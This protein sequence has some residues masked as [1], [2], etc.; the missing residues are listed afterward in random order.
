MVTGHE[1]L[2]AHAGRKW[3]AELGRNFLVWFIIVNS[4]V[5]ELNLVFERNHWFFW[6]EFKDDH[7]Y[8][9]LE[10][11]GYPEI[12]YT[13]IHSHS[14]HEQDSLLIALTTQRTR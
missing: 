5:G 8:I 6:Y 10:K 14:T 9:V 12:A 13:V 2:S 1:K 4:R 11:S 3:A 7:G